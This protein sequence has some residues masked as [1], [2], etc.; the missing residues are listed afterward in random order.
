MYVGSVGGNGVHVEAAGHYAGY[1]AGDVRITGELDVT[2]GSA[3]GFFPRPAYDSGWRTIPACDARI[4]THG[5]GGDVDNY[6]VDMQFKD[7]DPGLFSGINIL[8]LGGHT[9]VND[10]ARGGYW[11]HLTDSEITVVRFCDANNADQI[12]VRIWVYK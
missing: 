10:G 2:D 7:T 9:N 6:V 5:L 12:R 1:F 11:T 4:W 3:V 8:G